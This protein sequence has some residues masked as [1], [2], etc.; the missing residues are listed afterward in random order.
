MDNDIVVPILQ[1]T[2]FIIVN[3]SEASALVLF[4]LGFDLRGNLYSQHHANYIRMNF[5]VE[6]SVSLL[7]KSITA[8]RTTEYQMNL[9]NVPKGPID[10]ERAENELDL[11]RAPG[12]SRLDKH[13]KVSILFYLVTR[14]IKLYSIQASLF[15]IGCET[16]NPD[17][18]SSSINTVFR[19]HTLPGLA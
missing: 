13:M 12:K 6:K 4:H 1:S 8:H 5:I 10:I 14:N 7:L 2:K 17:L 15:E 18:R 3:D 9:L 19:I 11:G 16:V